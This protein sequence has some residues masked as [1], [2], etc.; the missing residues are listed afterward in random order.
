MAVDFKTGNSNLIE[1]I[2]NLIY[3]LNYFASASSYDITFQTEAQE[4][5]SHVVNEVA[6]MR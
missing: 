5:I 3:S 1:N 4:P 2:V 6:F